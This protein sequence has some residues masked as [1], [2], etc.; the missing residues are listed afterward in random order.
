MPD[1]PEE[2]AEDF[3]AHNHFIIRIIIIAWTT[4][5]VV[6]GVAAIGSGAAL[7]LGPPNSRASA[8]GGLIAQFDHLNTVF[9]WLL[10]VGGIALVIRKLVVWGNLLLGICHGW[11]AFLIV[12]ITL[13][14]HQPSSLVAAAWVGAIMLIHFIAGSA[15]ISMWQFVRRTR[16]LGRSRDG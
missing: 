10:I 2:T 5:S 7:L 4:I 1:Q 14:L 11:W 6:L 9:S 12:Y 15:R 13:F 8:A 16:H 3:I